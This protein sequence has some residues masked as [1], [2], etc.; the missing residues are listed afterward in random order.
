M[1]RRGVDL[2]RDCPTL[3]AMRMI[4]FLAGLW[5]AAP[6]LAAAQ[7]HCPMPPDI[8]SA[9]DLLFDQI[10]E[11]QNEMAARE[12]SNGLWELWVQAPDD[13]AQSLLQEG[14]DRRGSFDFIGAR[15]ALDRLVDYCPDYA[16]GWN[17]RAFVAFLTEDYSA[18]LA[19]LDVALGLNPRHLGALTGKVLTLIG[20][21]RGDEAQVTLRAA[22]ALNPWLSERALLQEP[23]GEDI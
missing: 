1:Q 21:G 9:E 23:P 20:M 5:I 4:S 14:M 8:G 16:E 13:A 6:T 15:A 10:A 22:L 11:A 3:S 17:Q 18:A 2:R 19:D 7:T 12:L